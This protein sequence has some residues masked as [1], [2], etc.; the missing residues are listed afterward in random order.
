MEIIDKFI[1]QVSKTNSILVNTWKQGPQYFFVGEFLRHWKDNKRDGIQIG[2][3]SDHL[4]YKHQF[5]A[6]VISK[7]YVYNRHGS[8]TEMINYLHGVKHGARR[9]WQRG[10]L[11]VEETYNCGK[12]NGICRYWHFDGTHKC[13]KSYLYGELHGDCQ[14]RYESGNIF[15]EETYLRGRIIPEKCKYWDKH[16]KLLKVKIADRFIG[17]DDGI[18]E[19]IDFGTARGELLFNTIITEITCTPIDRTQRCIIS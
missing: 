14:L 11:L 19:Y 12:L 16:G 10:H 6:G 18:I 13:T 3:D 17:V 7:S 4:S 5:C 2:W 1:I 8:P 15:A 9:K